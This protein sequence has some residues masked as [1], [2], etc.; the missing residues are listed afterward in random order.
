MKNSFTFDPEYKL[1]GELPQGTQTQHHQFI[2]SKRSSQF[3]RENS[4][5]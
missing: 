3:Q 2:L 1:K 4:G 5:G